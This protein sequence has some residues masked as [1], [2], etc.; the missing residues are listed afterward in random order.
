M[1]AV[2][3]P[4][5]F[6]QAPTL[7]DPTSPDTVTD[8]VD[9]YRG[10]RDR[11]VRYAG[12]WVNGRD[13]AEDVVQ[14]AF[15]RL[16][17]KGT[18]AR[19]PAAL[20]TS[21]T[22]GEALKES[23]RKDKR[24]VPVGEAMDWQPDTAPPA[25]DLDTLSA[26][27]GDTATAKAVDDALAKLPERQSR[28]IRMHLLQGMKVSEIATAL[29]I[30]KTTV[31][32][33]LNVGME[34]LRQM[35]VAL[36]DDEPE[37]VTEAQDAAPKRRVGAPTASHEELVA[38]L[39]RL[40][41]GTWVGPRPAEETLRRIHHKCSTVRAIRAQKAHN[42]TCEKPP[43][44]T[45][46]TGLAD[47]AAKRKS[48]T[49]SV[50]KVVATEGPVVTTDPVTRTVVTTV[51]VPAPTASQGPVVAEVWLMG[52]KPPISCL[53]V[54]TDETT[55]NRDLAAVS[56]LGAQREVTGQL[57]GEGYRP[58]GPWVDVDPAAP[59]AMRKFHQAEGGQS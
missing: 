40:F 23:E 24:A 10:K 11:L 46:A 52:A 42:A 20:L 28:A 19:N 5:T 48:P 58:D 32:A 9:L 45:R 36:P 51:R 38:T 37:P 14:D 3:E 17:S 30:D 31:Y 33:A 6:M 4:P 55:A 56:M 2:M 35:N 12:R 29:G 54:H 41:P 39:D 34:A 49:A 22:R 16:L 27:M 43:S 1:T 53:L 15:V 47:G 59:E 13:T 50:T 44:K 57:I 21:Y 7:K 25:E 8:L 18:E 26:C